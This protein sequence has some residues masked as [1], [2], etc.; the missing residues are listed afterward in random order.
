MAKDQPQRR[1]KKVWVLAKEQ[2]QWRLQKA[3]VLK[4]QPWRLQMTKKQPQW[5]LLKE[6]RWPPQK[7]WTKNM[8]D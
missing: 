8:I 2:P 3:R 1:L 6:C 4:E 7:Q 5:H